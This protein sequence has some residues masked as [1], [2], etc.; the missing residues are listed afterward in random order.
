MW[1]GKL[2]P[3]CCR[4]MGGAPVNS[5]YPAGAKDMMQTHHF[6]AR[7]GLSVGVW[8]NPGVLPTTGGRYGAQAAMQ[9]EFGVRNL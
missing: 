4:G 9:W 5:I 8:Y 3:V 7:A 2:L 6:C 1:I